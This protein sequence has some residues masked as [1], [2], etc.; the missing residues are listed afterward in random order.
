M[1]PLINDF[2]LYNLSQPLQ[3]QETVELCSPLQSILS[4][5]SAYLSC[6][7]KK[8]KFVFSNTF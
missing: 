3:V 6:Y 7:D 5:L 8:L 1:F 2:N 4:V